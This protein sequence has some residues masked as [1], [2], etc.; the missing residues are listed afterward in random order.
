MVFDLSNK[1]VGTYYTDNNGRIDLVGI[2][3]EGRYTIREIRPASNY[4]NDDIPR[5]VEIRPL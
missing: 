2:L 3:P 1:V 5:T 4:Y